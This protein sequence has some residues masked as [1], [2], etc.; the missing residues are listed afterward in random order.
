MTAQE[1]FKNL[2]DASSGR[3][4]EFDDDHLKI[5]LREGDLQ[6]TQELVEKMGRSDTTV[7]KH[8]KSFGFTH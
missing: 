1:G 6:T 3:R 7:V 2:T 4:S 8:L 5:P